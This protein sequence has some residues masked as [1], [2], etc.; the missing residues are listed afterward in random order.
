VKLDKEKKL[1]WR[2]DFSHST[3][4]DFMKKLLIFVALIALAGSAMAQDTP[5]RLSPDA[6]T[7]KENPA[8]PKGVQIASSWETRRKQ[9]MW[10]SYGLNSRLTSK[11]R[12][13][14][15]LIPRL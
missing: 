6:L 4:E 1:E 8:F 9:G 7:W 2:G 3:R 15:I 10:L 11:C 13:T 14:L 5:T 12:R